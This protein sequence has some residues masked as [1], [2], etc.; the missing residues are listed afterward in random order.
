MLNDILPQLVNQSEKQPKSAYSSVPEQGIFTL[1]QSRMRIV[2][3]TV[4][5]H[6][7]KIEPVNQSIHM[8]RVNLL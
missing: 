1:Q 8:K 3:S 2:E 6:L 5:T 4:D 7:V